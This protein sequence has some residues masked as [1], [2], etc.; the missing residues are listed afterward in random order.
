MDEMED[1]V[2]T[3]PAL[4]TRIESKYQDIVAKKN[5]QTKNA[6]LARFHALRSEL[7][8][9]LSNNDQVNALEKLDKDEFIINLE[10]QRRLE[11][12][13]DDRAHQ[14]NVLLLFSVFILTLTNLDQS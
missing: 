5:E 3:R 10:E 7:Q 1:D 8:L 2:S 11:Q 6:R 12:E 14:G 13:G 4:F 9:L